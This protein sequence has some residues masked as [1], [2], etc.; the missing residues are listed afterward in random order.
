MRIRYFYEG[1]WY[2]G[3]DS[4]NQYGWNGVDDLPAG[5]GVGG[6]DVQFNRL[7]QV[8]EVTF[9]L[10][11]SKGVLDEEEN[12]PVVIRRLIELPQ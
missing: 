2:D 8:V 12:N 10:V 3:W 5:A 6:D 1:Q 4:T 11:D 9:R 7:P